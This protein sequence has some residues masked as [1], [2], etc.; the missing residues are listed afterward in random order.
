MQKVFIMFQNKGQMWG[1][2]LHINF[3]MYVRNVLSDGFNWG[4]IELYHLWIELILEAAQRV[5]S[6]KANRSNPALDFYLFDTFTPL[7]PLP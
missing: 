3:G 6:T 1:L 7:S 4:Y 5:E 2:T